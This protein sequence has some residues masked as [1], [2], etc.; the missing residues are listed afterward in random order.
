MANLIPAIDTTTSALNAERTR[1][2]I[3]AANLANANTTRGV[4]GLPYRRKQVVFETMIDQNLTIQGVNT[5]GVKV[6][7]IIE[8]QKPFEKRLMP[9]HPHAD[10]NGWVTLPNV[11]SVTEMVDLMTANRSYE[12]NL[13][14][15]RMA[16]EM[17][18]RSIALAEVK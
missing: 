14:V 7:K 9:G 11:D 3:V 18:S 2:E 12:A 15:M 4:N 6:S 8:D 13:Q 1:L 16:R 17:T 10:A 5:G